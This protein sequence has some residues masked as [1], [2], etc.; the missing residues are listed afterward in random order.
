M[1]VEYKEIRGILHRNC[2]TCGKFFPV[3][4]TASYCKECIKAYKLEYKK[5]TKEQ[6]V[7]RAKDF[8]AE[9]QNDPDVIK[10]QTESGVLLG[11]LFSGCP[12]LFKRAMI[13]GDTA[14]F[15]RLP[16]PVRELPKTKTEMRFKGVL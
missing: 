16:V 5:K 3:R 11:G 13:E 12:E 7:G 10:K 8:K 6:S 9:R 14:L 2:A 1:A 15:N 4:G